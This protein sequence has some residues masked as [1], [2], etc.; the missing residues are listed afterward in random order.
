M[1]A[2]YSVE[3]IMLQAELYASDGNLLMISQGLPDAMVIGPGSKANFW[4][5]VSY[6]QVINPTCKVVVDSASIAP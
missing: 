2:K 1:S 3:N 5:W 6:R 4:L